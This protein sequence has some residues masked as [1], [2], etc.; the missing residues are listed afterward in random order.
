MPSEEIYERTDANKSSKVADGYVIYDTETDRVH[1][2]NI[3]AAVIYELCDGV[4]TVLG[5]ARA[6]DEG[7]HLGSLPLE[8][9]EICLDKLR[10]ERLVR[11]C[12]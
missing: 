12:R 8:E 6:I 3:T 9:V 10:S 7:Y 1:F 4:R 2:L 11:K 5:I